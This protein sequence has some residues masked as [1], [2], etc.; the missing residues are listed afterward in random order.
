VG[1]GPRRELVGKSVRVEIDDRR[2]THA[3]NVT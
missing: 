2:F 1:D 3:S